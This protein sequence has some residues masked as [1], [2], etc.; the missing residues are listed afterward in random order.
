MQLIERRTDVS[1]ILQ[2]MGNIQN[3]TDVVNQPLSQTFRDLTII[4]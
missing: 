1:N 3:N 4:Y 2:T